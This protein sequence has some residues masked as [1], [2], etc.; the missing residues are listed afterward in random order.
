MIADA[1]A[2]TYPARAVCTDTD[3]NFTNSTPNIDTVMVAA[4]S[5]A[6]AI[7]QTE[8]FS[9]PSPHRDPVSSPIN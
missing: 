4:V 2:G 3:G 1:D 5:T 9:A 7:F 8:S 6:G